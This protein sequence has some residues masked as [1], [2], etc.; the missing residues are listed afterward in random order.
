VNENRCRRHTRKLTKRIAN[1]Q[2]SQAIQ[3]LPPKKHGQPRSTT[4]PSQQQTQEPSGFRSRRVH[5]HRKGYVEAGR[6]QKICCH[7][8]HPQTD[9]E[10]GKTHFRNMRS[11]C[12]C[13]MCLQFT[14]LHAASCVLHRPTSQVIHRS[15]L[16]FYRNG[17]AK[18]IDCIKRVKKKFGGRFQRYTFRAQ[19]SVGTIHVPSCH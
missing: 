18:S 8:Y 5:R 2:A 9:V 3:C 17:L 15:E 7:F 6:G 13:S 14:L 12:R 11:K 10:A 16:S 1:R 4:A 19:V